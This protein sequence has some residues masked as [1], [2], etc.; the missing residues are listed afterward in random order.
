MQSFDNKKFMESDVALYGMFISVALV[1]SY[2]EAIIPIKLP[3]PGM[4]LGLANIIVIW[5]MYAMGIK[6]AVIIS[7]LRVLLSGFL[8]GSIY[9]MLFGLAGAA[10]SIT[11]MYFVRKINKFTMVGVSIAGGVSHNIGQIIVAVFILGNVRISYYLPFLMIS[12]IV[13]GVAIGIIGSIL[14]RKIKILPQNKKK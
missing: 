12:G 5:V 11:V 6:P 13:A 8:F 1:M 14:Y 4:K 7:I 2:I 9:S 3:V 10:L